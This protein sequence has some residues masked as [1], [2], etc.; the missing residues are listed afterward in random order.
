MPSKPPIHVLAYAPAGG[1]KSTFAASFPKPLLVL[2]FDPAGKMMPYLKRGVPSP[3]VEGPQGQGLVLVESK[4]KPGTNI[5]QVELFHDDE[6]LPD[7]EL[8]PVAFK[9]LLSRLP[10]LY[11]EV[12]SGMW[13]TV[14]IDSL[15]ALS[16][17]SKNMHQFDLHKSERD[18]R[19]W[20]AQTTDALEKLICTQLVGALRG[21]NFVVICHVDTDKDEIAG[22]M[23]STM[24]APGRL[25]TADGLPARFPEMYRLHSKRDKATGVIQR[26]V[27]TQVDERNNAMTAIGAPD[28]CAPDYAALWVS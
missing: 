27:Q 18:S 1:Y 17:A 28:G 22:T 3:E 21:I 25:R 9:R 8:K 2:G 7:G 26:W 5:I 20:F 14:V 19:K 6:I 24:A 15:T 13:A 10:S 16:L 23:V 11:D 4:T 12:R